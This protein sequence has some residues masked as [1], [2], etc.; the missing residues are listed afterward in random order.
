MICSSRTR[1]SAKV[2][3]SERE[4]IVSSVSHWPVMLT[5]GEAAKLSGMSISTIYSRVSRGLHK[6][7]VIRKGA[8]RFHRDLFLLE[9]LGVI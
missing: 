4:M 3:S 1:P 5:V 7:S 9:L 8:L 2:A 6:K